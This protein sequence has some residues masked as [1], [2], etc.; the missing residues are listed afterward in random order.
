MHNVRGQSVAS[1]MSE[2]TKNVRLCI[3]EALHKFIMVPVASENRSYGP[4]SSYSVEY[5]NRNQGRHFRFFLGGGA[6][7]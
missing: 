3:A 2:G 5:K 7:F 4:K 1:F 6:R